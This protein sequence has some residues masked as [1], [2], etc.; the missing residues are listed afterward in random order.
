[1]KIPEDIF[2]IADTS[3]NGEKDKILHDDILKEINKT[4]FPKTSKYQRCKWCDSCISSIGVFKLKQQLGG[5]KQFKAESRYKINQKCLSE[6]LHGKKY[7]GRKQKKHRASGTK[8]DPKLIED[9]EEEGE[10]KGEQ[11][12][13]E[14][15]EEQTGETSGK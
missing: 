15:P 9:K 4:C 7:L 2:A 6:I 1:M 14:G 12:E 8:D 3:D 11:E 10:A 5:A 13:P